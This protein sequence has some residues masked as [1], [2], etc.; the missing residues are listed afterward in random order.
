MGVGNK[1]PKEKEKEKAREKKKSQNKS[2]LC[3]MRTGQRKSD[4]FCT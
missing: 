1:K 4:T 2:K 3:L